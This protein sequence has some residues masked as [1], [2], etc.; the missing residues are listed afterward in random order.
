MPGKTRRE[1]VPRLPPPPPSE[2][3]VQRKLVDLVEGRVTREEADDWAMRWVVADDPGIEDKNIWAAIGHLAGCAMPT[4]DRA[5]LYGQSDFEAWLA[6][7]RG[8]LAR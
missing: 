1:R 3:E 2:D 6:D 4:T 5:Y 8:G 7:F